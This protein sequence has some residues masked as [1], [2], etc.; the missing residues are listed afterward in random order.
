[1]SQDNTASPA[2]TA[3]PS[4]LGAE[5][6][7]LLPIAIVRA[8]Q[9]AAAHRRWAADAANTALFADARQGRVADENSAANHLACARALEALATVGERYLRGELTEKPAAPLTSDR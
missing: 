3:Q 4:P 2:P 5:E 8:K 7:G 9:D 1:M 6:F